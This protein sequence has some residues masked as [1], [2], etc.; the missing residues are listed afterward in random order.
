[1]PRL[2]SIG[3]MSPQPKFLVLLD[4]AAARALLF[5]GAQHLLGE[6]IED[7]GFIVERLLVGARPCPMPHAGMLDTMVAP[8]S[9][10]VRCFE[11]R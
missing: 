8:P 10:P 2:R 6:V 5:D 3:G 9:Q 11:L 4:D 1:M 7:D